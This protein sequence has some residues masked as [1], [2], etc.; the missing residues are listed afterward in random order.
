[1]C[2]PPGIAV[3]IKCFIMKPSV[4]SPETP[5]EEPPLSIKVNPPFN[6]T[7]RKALL[8]CGILSS[9]VY[10]AAN[11]FGAL[12]WEGYSLTSQTVSELSAIGA[13][14]RPLVVLLMLTYGVL[15]IAFGWGV[16][17]SA[18]SKRV[19]RILAGL[20]AGFGIVCLTGPLTPMHQRQVLARGGETLTD[21]LHILFTIVDVVFI[22]LL[23]GFGAAAFGKK[24]RLYSI[25]TIVVLLL[26]GA[27]SGMDAPKLAADLPTPWIGVAERINIGVFLLWVVVLALILLRAEK[28]PG[29]I[30]RDHA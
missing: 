10:V 30:N 17:K 16:W 11:I 15:V 28:E 2:Y 25:A 7:F 18:G 24:F 23:I 13:P 22:V 19:L 27:L 6:Q 29:A 26:F 20:L 1:M 3:V 9:L 4:A 5:K 12:R 21:T 14:S 8:V